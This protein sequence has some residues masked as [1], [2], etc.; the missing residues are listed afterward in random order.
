MEEEASDVPDRRWDRHPIDKP[1]NG[2]PCKELAGLHHRGR[3][4]FIRSIPEVVQRL[5]QEA[6]QW[7]NRVKSPEYYA[8]HRGR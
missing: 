2:S 7:R 3:C 6:P 8:M 5:L 4:I 1:S